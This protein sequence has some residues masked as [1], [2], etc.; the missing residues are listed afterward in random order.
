MKTNKHFDYMPSVKIIWITLYLRTFTIEN[1]KDLI[2]RKFL[3]VTWQWIF[4]F[5]KLCASDLRPQKLELLSYIN[6]AWNQIQLLPYKLISRIFSGLAVLWEF[7]LI[8][9]K[10]VELI[11]IFREINF[12]SEHCIFQM[13]E[14]SRKLENIHNCIARKNW[15][16]ITQ[17]DQLLPC[18]Y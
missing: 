1:T 11:E 16:I 4:H 9:N 10:C 18:F 3:C 5:S 8:S 2:W 12:H 7:D 15:Y 6:I 13:K 14:F 17:I